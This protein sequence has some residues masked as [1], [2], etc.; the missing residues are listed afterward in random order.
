MYYC[1]SG[2]HLRWLHC[3]VQQSHN[4]LNITISQNFK[5][6]DTVGFPQAGQ[7]Q[8][9][10]TFYQEFTMVSHVYIHTVKHLAMHILSQFP[11]VTT[12]ADTES[13]ANPITLKP[14]TVTVN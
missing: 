4:R 13:L 12:E 8:N 5:M 1:I 7:I 10:N 14:T 3:Q 9:K 6:A 11:I 2:E